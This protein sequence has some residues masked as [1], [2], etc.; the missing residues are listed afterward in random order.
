[1]DI[2]QPLINGQTCGQTCGA[3]SNKPLGHPK[4]QAINQQEPA[5]NQ[6]RNQPVNWSTD[7]WNPKKRAILWW[8]NT[9]IEHHNFDIFFEKIG[10]S[11]ISIGDLYHSYLSL[12]EG[13]TQ[14][15]MRPTLPSLAASGTLWWWRTS[16]C[17]EDDEK[18]WDVG[19]SL[20][21]FPSY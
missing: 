21:M 3:L 14:P 18:T 8:F 19:C 12:L 6:L 5:F 11:S 2:K 15:R 4:N 20:G 9:A 16:R 1:M 17:Q 10:E 7:Q 13:N